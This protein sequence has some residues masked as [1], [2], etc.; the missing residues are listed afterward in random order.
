MRWL[1]FVLSSL[2]FTLGFVSGSFHLDPTY[3]TSKHIAFVCL[4]PGSSHI[5]WVLRF[6]DELA[7]RGHNITFVTV[8]R[9]YVYGA[10]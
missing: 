10:L 9:W 4:V 6:L 1:L 8:V 5:T 7:S 2:L 3:Q